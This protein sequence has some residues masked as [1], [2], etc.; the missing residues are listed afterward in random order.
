MEKI[1]YVCVFWTILIPIP[2]YPW[3]QYHV[4]MCMN[5][6]LKKNKRFSTDIKLQSN[7]LS[8]FPGLVSNSSH[9]KVSIWIVLKSLFQSYWN[10]E[11]KTI[12][13]KIWDIDNFTSLY[14]CFQL[15]S[16]FSDLEK[17]VKDNSKGIG[18]KALISSLI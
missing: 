10:K 16:V 1:Y 13:N 11:I 18:I 17:I 12:T 7:H 6:L 2:S 3:F 15:F 5:K 4:T 8:V 9:V 14:L